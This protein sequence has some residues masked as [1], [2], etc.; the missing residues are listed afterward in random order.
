MSNS[1]RQLDLGA[2]YDTLMRKKAVDA[3]V[4]G[5]Q[6]QGQ[7]NALQMARYQ[8]ENDAYDQRQSAL[9]IFN[10]PNATLEQQQSALSRA[11]PELRAQALFTPKTETQVVVPSGG[12][13]FDRRTGTWTY[14]D[15]GPVLEGDP[16]RGSQPPQ[17]P[18]PTIT[19]GGHGP[20]PAP[21]QN[22]LSV[23]IGASESGGKGPGV[24]NGQGYSGKYQFGEAAAAAA[25]FYEPDDNPNDNKWNGKFKGLPGVNSYQDFL[26]SEAAQDQAFNMH[27]THLDAEIEGRG[28]GKYIGQ[29]VG[30]VQ[31]TRDGLIGMMH[32]GGPA[33]TQ[34]YLE[35][36]GQ[37]NPSDS[38]GTRI[39]DYGKK[40]AGDQGGAPV[41][42]QVDQHVIQVLGPELAN[43]VFAAEKA[44]P[45]ALLTDVMPPEWVQQHPEAAG[46][47]IAQRRQEI[48]SRFAGTAP[49][50]GAQ[51]EQ[52]QGD[53]QQAGD[54]WKRIQAG[55][56]KSLGLHDAPTGK[57][58]VGRRNPDTGQIETKV[59]PIPGTENE[60]DFGKGEDAANYRVYRRLS[61]K[62]AKG[63][64]LTEDEQLDL[65]FSVRQL[66]Q[67]RVVTGPDGKSREIAPPP[68]PTRGS[69]QQGQQTQPQPAP[70]P[71]VSTVREID[72]PPVGP[73]VAERKTINDQ[74]SVVDRFDGAL[75]ALAE[76]VGTNGLSLFAVGGGGGRQSSLY[77]DVLL[78]LKELQN[79]GV[80]NGGDERILLEQLSDPTALM[81]WIRGG[82]DPAYFK[83]QL[84]AVQEKVTRER[85]LLKGRLNPGQSTTA[86]GTD[87]G[88]M[89]RKD[90]L[91]LDTDTMSVDQINAWHAALDSAKGK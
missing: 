14:P 26:G 88:S 80:L 33:G 38:N 18:R 43:K 20:I 48:E 87:Y 7:M 83:E 68:L 45:N 34:K 56:L 15:Q 49:Q 3:Q 79:L 16:A 53:T 28:L 60:D 17:Q 9:A 46:V 65:D 89:S 10:D 76:D 82:G 61:A 54:G 59:A 31:I 84:K 50:Q 90:L 6:Q 13:V 57:M 25:G 29:T 8:R 75:K 35:S 55:G 11:F 39:S 77:K 81:T 30:G 66:N 41:A 91:A 63:E 24:V 40:F 4:A 19:T 21:P 2:V 32:L 85:G 37:Y 70:Q 69:K 42:S 36:G 72:T 64:T 44:N 1:I 73:S 12:A 22:P 86:G 27:Q 78:Q 51:P 71:G 67:P 62:Q 52:T 5:Q 23:R 58:W 74:I 47:T